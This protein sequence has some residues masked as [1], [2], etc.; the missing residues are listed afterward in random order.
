[1]IQSPRDGSESVVDRK[2]PASFD[3]APFPCNDPLLFVIPSVPGFP[4]SLLSL[5]TSDVVLF[6]ENHTQPTEAENSR[7]EIRGSRGICGAPLVCPVASGPQPPTNHPPNP[8]GNTNL[9]IVIPSSR[10]AE[11]SQE[12]TSRSFFARCG[13]PRSSTGNFVGLSLGAGFPVTLLCRDDKKERATV[14]KEA[15]SKSNLEDSNWESPGHPLN[16][17]TA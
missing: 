4:A 5:A 17:R 16:E 7:Q 9:R 11:A 8:H 10:L 1:L 2:R 15:L 14:R 12:R 13:I 6:K 3:K